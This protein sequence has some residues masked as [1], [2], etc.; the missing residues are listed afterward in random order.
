MLKINIYNSEGKVAGEQELAP[1]VFEV[2]PD[3]KIIHFVVNG[4][5]AN[6]RQVLAHT[7]TR[8]EVRGGGKKPWKQKGTG[9]ARH[10]SIRSPLWRG[11]GVIFGPL[12]DRNFK[13]KIN[14]KTKQLAF[15]MI[16]SDR[17]KEQSLIL[18]ENLN[19]D[20][21]A[22]EAKT[23]N[24]VKFLKNLSLAGQKVLIIFPSPNEKTRL[25]SR[26]LP[27]IQ[28]ENLNEVNLLD[29]LNNDK[30]LTTPEA[31]AYWQKTYK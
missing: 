22:G 25:A 12:K 15:K 16:L 19:L 18:A 23:K 27:R 20:S 8:G 1:E 30:I 24:A 3:L 17:V 28:Q 9:R 6:Q 26:N 11:G 10:G 14:K 31:I 5:M 13:I 7:L 21:P 2:K 4:L 29:I